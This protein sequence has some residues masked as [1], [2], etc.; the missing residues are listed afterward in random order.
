M[1]TIFYASVLPLLLLRPTPLPSQIPPDTI[2]LQLRSEIPFAGQGLPQTVVQDK[3]NQPYCYIAAKEGGLRIFNIQD[4]TAPVLEKT[5]AVA[6]LAGEEVMNVWQE[7]THLYLALGNFFNANDLHKPGLAIVN[8]SDP[9]NAFVTDTWLWNIADRGC[10]FVTVSGAYAYLGA[11]SQGLIILDVADKDDIKFAS[12]FVPDIHFPVQ[13]P[14]DIQ[15]PN[16]RGMAVRDNTVFLC[17]DAGG[18]RVIDVSDK[19]SP[20]ETGRYINQ[21]ALGKQQA[22]NNIILKDDTAFVAVDFCGMEI[23]DISDADDISEISWWN[24]WD[25]QSL[26]NTWFNSPGHCNQIQFDDAK[27]LVFLSAGR[28]ELSIVDVSDVIHPQQVGA[29]G[30]PTDNYFTWGVGLHGERIYLT[31]ISSLWP[32]FSIWAGV[33]ILEWNGVSE[34]EEPFKITSNCL[35]PNPFQSN[36]NLDFELEKSSEVHVEIADP[37]GRVVTVWKAGFY[38]PGKHTLHWEGNLAAGLYVVRLNTSQ[39]R[40]IGKILQN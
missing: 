17:Y 13:N 11:M 40:A 16:A 27:R 7:G 4:I 3:N 33:K 12:Q 38:A 39:G 14:N 32:F 15:M 8:V 5:I 37:Q 2:L 18:L 26:S 29:Y 19:S 28:S 1:K 10:A 20:A 36:F 6:E 30:S 9:A 34:A 31:Y 24:P 23:L 22:Y 21:E 25:C 35:Y